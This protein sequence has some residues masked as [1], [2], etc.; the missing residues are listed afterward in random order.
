MTKHNRLISANYFLLLAN[1]FA[2]N[3]IGLVMVISASTGVSDDGAR[4]V[5]SQIIYTVIGFLLMFTISVLP[6]Q[7]FFRFSNIFLIAAC[8]LQSAVLSPLGVNSGGNTNWLRFG[9][10]TLQP[11]ELLKLA[12]IL[13]LATGLTKRRSTSSDLSKGVI[14]S[15][16]VILAVCG[17]VFLGNDLGNVLIIV[18]I[19]FGV[20]IFANIPMISLAFPLGVFSGIVFLA[21][22]LSP[23]RM[24]RILNFL[25]ISCDKVDQ[26]YLTLCWQPIQSVWALANGNV[27]GVGLGRSVAKW[28]WLPSATSDYIFAI[29]GEELGFV[30]SISL[31][32]LFLFLAITMVRIARDANDLFARS[33]IGGVMFWLVGQALINIA[34]VLRFFPVLGVTLPFVSAGGSALTTSMMAVGLVLGLIRRSSRA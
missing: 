3:A 7:F 27:A 33:I 17:L 29:L 15:F 26:H 25:N 2:L 31:I 10:I 8:I 12:V 9:P 1:V 19:F 14:P 4:S 32:L 13:W 5:I 18:I 16:V 23:N 28:N 20:M 34:V 24:G 30:G 21:A 6:E 11:S 22:T